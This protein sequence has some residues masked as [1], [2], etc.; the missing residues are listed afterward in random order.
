[1]PTGSSQL[2]CCW[3]TTCSVLQ[4]HRTRENQRICSTG[5]SVHNLVGASRLPEHSQL[6]KNDWPSQLIT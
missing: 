6:I 2:V 5:H 1:V 4:V 3:S